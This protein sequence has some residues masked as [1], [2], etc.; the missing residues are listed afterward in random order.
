VIINNN[1]KWSKEVS[2]Y[3]RVRFEEL[4]GLVV[5]EHSPNEEESDFRT[6]ITRVQNTDHDGIFTPL[7]LHTDLLYRQ[8]RDAEYTN[9]IIAS[10]QVTQQV[11][12][13][14][15]GAAE[16]TYHTVLLVPEGDRTERFKAL[17]EKHYGKTTDQLLYVGLGY[18]GA[19]TLMRAAELGG[20]NPV[21][22][23]DSMYEI[24]DLDGAFSAISI[25]ENGSY[26]RYERVVQVRNGV[27]VLVQ[28]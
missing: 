17:Y 13:A 27:D 5:D 4:G 18:D 23:K 25:D 3:F 21:A 28:E 2:G 10:D 9:P 1:A 6:I 8:L 22:I 16:G 26:S 12:D 7:G 15:N 14:A 19:K 20:T 11:I 24:K